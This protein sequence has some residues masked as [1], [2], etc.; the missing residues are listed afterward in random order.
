MKIGIHTFDEY[1]D[2]IRD[3]HGHVAPGLVIGGFMVD[4]ALKNL[5]KG[6][7][8]DAISETRSCLPDAIQLLTPCTIGNGWLQILDLGRY[9][10]AFFEKYTGTGVRIYVDSE[11]LEAWPEINSWFFKLKPK[12]EQDFDLL[13]DQIENAGS[14]ILSTQNVLVAK[15]LVG[16]KHKGTISKCSMCN[17]AYPTAHGL[18]CRS[19]HGDTPYKEV[20]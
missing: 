15:S 13:M 1:I 3:F 5:P 18:V 9:A 4:T 8:F 20:T 7:F 2:L 12:K 10:L 14:D 11:K 19:C 17:E 6:E 16:P